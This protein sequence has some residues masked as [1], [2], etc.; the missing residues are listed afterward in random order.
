MISATTGD[1]LLL[2][3]G[4]YKGSFIINKG[5][6]VSSSELFGAVIDAGGRGIAV[7][8]T[9]DASIIGCQI[10]NA[11]IGVFSDGANNRI[12]SCKIH[13][14]WQSGIVIVRH[15]PWIV[16]NL[17]VFN[18]ASGIQ[19]WDCRSSSAS[20]NHNTIAYNQNHGLSFGGVSEV[21]IENNLIAFNQKLAIKMR[22][23]SRATT[24]THNNFYGNLNDKRGIQ[25]GN[26]SFD[27]AFLSK[28][29]NLNFKS[30][31]QQCCKKTGND[32]KRIGSRLP[33]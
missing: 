24:L 23:E 5:V 27:P 30:D 8:L 18:R 32:N 19:G 29:P 4:V 16:D 28:T 2:A 31:P 33:E 12:Q 1:T 21:L 6:T 3:N 26:F 7:T 17:I 22:D 11:T 10:T 13:K 9:E 15:V 14:N 25:S 20:V